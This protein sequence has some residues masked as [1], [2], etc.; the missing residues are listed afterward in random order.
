MFQISNLFNY[1]LSQSLLFFKKGDT[2]YLNIEALRSV[3]KKKK[4]KKGVYC[5]DFGESLQRRLNMKNSASMIQPR[6][7]PLKFGLLLPPRA[8]PRGKKTTMMAFKNSTMQA[9]SIWKY[10]GALGLSYFLCTV[11][12]R[13]KSPTVIANKSAMDDTTTKILVVKNQR[14]FHLGNL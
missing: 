4:E 11:W 3:E 6:T 14:R 13:T 7:S 12:R 1:N 8:H 10:S 5:V 9:L 2:F